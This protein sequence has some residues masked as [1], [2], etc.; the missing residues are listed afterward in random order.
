MRFPVPRNL[1]A[2][3]AAAMLF[4]PSAVARAGT[5]TF[6]GSLGGSR[7]VSAEATFVTSGTTLTLTLR[8]TSPTPTTIHPEQVLTSFYFDLLDTDGTRVPLVCTGASGNVYKLVGGGQPATPYLYTPAATAGGSPVYTPVTLPPAQ[9]S[10]ILATTKGDGSWMFRS[11][12]DTTRE[13]Y[14]FYG[15]GTV[16]N[17]TL[18]PNNFPAKI[19][20]Q[21]E[22]GIFAGSGSDPA[23][24]LEV[25][26]PYLV[27]DSATFTFTSTLNLDA[28][29][30]RDP[31]VFGFGTDPDQMIVLTPEPSGTALMAAAALAAGGAAWRRRALAARRA[32]GAG[33]EA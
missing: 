15:I 28:F 17:S 6:G 19:V 30:V 22:F 32:R 20:N 5:F 11:G 9:P 33:V 4:A 7:P 8:N 26:M 23:G 31:F 13:P 12:L 14:C 24:L 16:G 10:D 29:V 2:L 3:F 21:I 27:K 1:R 25:R 18:D